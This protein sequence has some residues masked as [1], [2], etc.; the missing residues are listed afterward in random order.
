MAGATRGDLLYRK[1][2]ARQARGIVVGLDIASQQCN[3][4]PTRKTLQ[5]PLQQ[6][7]FAASG[8][9]DQ[10]E[11]ENSTFLKTRAQSGGNATI[12]VKNFAL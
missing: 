10:I 9:A 2:K 1:T 7:R 11:A 5:S 12:F 8:R 4:F 6:R 3:S